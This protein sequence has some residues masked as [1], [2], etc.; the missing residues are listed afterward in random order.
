MMSRVGLE[1]LEYIMESEFAH[2]SI[3]AVRRW[4]GLGMRLSKLPN[5]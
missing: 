5:W 1:K 3:S 2:F 4:S